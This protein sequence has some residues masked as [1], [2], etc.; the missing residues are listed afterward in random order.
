VAMTV[1]ADALVGALGATVADVT[2]APEP[3][4]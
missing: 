4:R 3:T 1:D 2:V